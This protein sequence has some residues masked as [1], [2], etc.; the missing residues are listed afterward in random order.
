MALFKMVFRADEAECEKAFIEM[1][2]KKDNARMHAR[3]LLGW[4]RNMPQMPVNREDRRGEPYIL[5][6][7]G[8]H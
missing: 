4:A 2:K 1:T 3:I 7:A 5:S 8:R 6:A